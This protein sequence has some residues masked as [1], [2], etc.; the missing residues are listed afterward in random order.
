MKHTLHVI[1]WTGNATAY[2]DIPLAEAELRYAKDNKY[3]DD[4]WMTSSDIPKPPITS[5]EFND[6]FMVYDAWAIKQIPLKERQAR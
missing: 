5:F 3:P 2:L 4:I 1:G 6:E